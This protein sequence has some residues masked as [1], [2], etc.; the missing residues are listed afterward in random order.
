MASP[1][2]IGQFDLNALRSSARCRSSSSTGALW[3]T[4][5]ELANAIFE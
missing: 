5:A 1:G 4:R 2:G 3:A